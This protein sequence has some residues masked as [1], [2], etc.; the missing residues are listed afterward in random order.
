M[1][2]CSCS[3]SSVWYPLQILFILKTFANLDKKCLNLN[4]SMTHELMEF[5]F[6]WLATK[7]QSTIWSCIALTLC[8]SSDYVVVSVYCRHSDSVKQWHNGRT[9]FRPLITTIIFFSG[10]QH[11]FKSANTVFC[12]F[13]PNKRIPSKTF[14]LC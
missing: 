7:E 11:Q 8:H 1:F 14:F 3:G 12:I 13:T 6:S 4:T 10:G 5:E 2:L 9:G